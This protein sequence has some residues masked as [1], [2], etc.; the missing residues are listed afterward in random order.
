MKERFP[1]VFPLKVADFRALALRINLALEE[2]GLTIVNKQK[3]V[4]AITELSR[5]NADI[6]PGQ[7]LKILSDPE[8]LFVD[9]IVKGMT[10][11]YLTSEW[12]E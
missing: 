3:T 1:S 7:I 11:V 5:Q 8:Q 4:E 6:K 9:A 2:R 12:S 10:I